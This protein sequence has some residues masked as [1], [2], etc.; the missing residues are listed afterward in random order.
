MNP[1]DTNVQQP[2]DEETKSQ[3]PAQKIEDLDAT[4][5]EE[6]KGGRT[7]EKHIEIPSWS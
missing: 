3:E 6:V 4:D 1:P 2:E 7:G 5:A